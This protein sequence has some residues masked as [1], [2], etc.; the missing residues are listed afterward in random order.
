[1]RVRIGDLRAAVDQEPKHLRLRTV[2][3]GEQG[4]RS[5]DLA[6]RGARLAGEGVRDGEA[7]AK[8]RDAPPVAVPLADPNPGS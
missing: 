5:V 7:T 6:P 8:E 2:A 4:D 3:A 1:M